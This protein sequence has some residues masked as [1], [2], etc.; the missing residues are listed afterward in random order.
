MAYTYMFENGFISEDTWS[1]LMP[2]ERKLVADDLNK[3]AEARGLDIRIQ[4]GEHYR[5]EQVASIQHAID[6]YD[7][8]RE[9]EKKNKRKRYEN[10][11]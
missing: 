8:E 3:S 9:K 5:I 4:Y 6:N 7:M 11:S 2:I 10:N 1:I